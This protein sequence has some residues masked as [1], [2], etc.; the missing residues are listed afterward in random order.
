MMRLHSRLVQIRSRVAGCAA[1]ASGP[2]PGLPAPGVD[3]LVS[4]II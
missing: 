2:L 3:D 1:G 4:S